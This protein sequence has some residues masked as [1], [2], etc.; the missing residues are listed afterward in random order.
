VV[1]V[2]RPRPWAL[3]V[4][5]ACA[6]ASLAVAVLAPDIVRRLVATG[7]P[8]FP[9]LKDA[10]YYAGR[11]RLTAL[12]WALVLPVFFIT[13]DTLRGRWKILISPHARTAIRS[14][15]LWLFVL[16][17]VVLT[18]PRDRT[19]DEPSYL[20]M[21][22]AIVTHGSLVLS[23]DPGDLHLSL[24]STEPRSVHSP[25][26]SILIAIPM[27]LFGNA[28]IAL[29]LVAISLG[30]LL[31]VWKML[32][33]V[34][35][36]D[37]AA[38]VAVL[39]AASFPVV[40]YAPL[41]L[42]EMAGAFGFAY[43]H[44]KL[45][46]KRWPDW[47][48]AV[49]LAALPWMHVRFIAGALIYCAYGL[50]RPGEGSRRRAVARLLVPLGASLAVMGYMHQR[51]F[52][53]PSPLAMWGGRTDLVS[54]SNA[55]VGSLGVLVDQQY[56]LLI[57]APIMLLVPLGFLR[58]LRESREQALVL[59][60]V[61]VATAGPG[62]LVQWWGGWSAA[63][64]FLV[65][66]TGQ[67]AL[68]AAL[69]LAR[70]LHGGATDR[71]AAGLAVAGQLAIGAVCALVPG[72]VF[73]TFEAAPRNYYLDLLGRALG[74]DSLRSFLALREA[75]GWKPL[76]FAACV[77]MVWLAGSYLWAR[78]LDRLSEA[79]EGDGSLKMNEQAGHE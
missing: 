13:A 6:A 71:I 61:I 58:H 21:A 62:I 52:G 12:S 74:L 78:R 46:R 69:G 37:L 40:T 29:V 77:V 16:L 48:A 47:G 60:A 33:G 73:G 45:V 57:W 27:A 79:R 28:G 64:R 35:G 24:A 4:G 7:F 36:G 11:L 38:F 10:G 75:E 14:V 42:P 25:G 72:K 67:L 18:V 76:V 66:V 34:V 63:A 41:V 2:L 15:G 39:L 5:L 43:L 68:L 22:R 56:G 19:G 70:A 9:G 8:I 32:S 59:G 55:L 49:V 65:P 50:L 51:W 53:S 23:G 1:V 26:I 31:C 20:A 44:W 3:V 54:A 30:F 17:A